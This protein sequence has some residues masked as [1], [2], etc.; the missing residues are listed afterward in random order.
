MS[1][2]KVIGFEG[3]VREFFCDYLQENKGFIEDGDEEYEFAL[4]QAVEA[5]NASV[6]HSLRG[7]TAAGLARELT[8]QAV[9]EGEIVP[10]GMLGNAK[11]LTALTK[12]FEK[13]F[14]DVFSI[15][16]LPRLGGVHLIDKA[17]STHLYM[18]ADGFCG[19]STGWPAKELSGM[20]LIVGLFWL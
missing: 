20:S 11:Y 3:D 4:K 13:V 18:D 12:T 2:G 9:E 15:R 6:G 19:L 17:V 1:G 5:Y 14:H 8:N 7:F 10:P 16:C